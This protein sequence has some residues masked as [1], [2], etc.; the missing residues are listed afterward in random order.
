MKNN[1]NI[2]IGTDP[3]LFIIN[4]RT[5]KIV[6]A[7]PFI[8][9]TK[10]KPF[11][12]NIFT[13]GFAVQTD[14]VLAEFNIPPVQNVQDFIT[15]LE[16]MKEYIRQL[17]KQHNPDLDI[18]CQAS[19]EL[20]PIELQSD[21][22]KLFGCDPDFNVY[23]EDVN[24][25]PKAKLQNLRTTGMHIHIGFEPTISVDKKLLIIRLL[26]LYL[27]MP[28][29]LLDQD[30][31]RRKLYGKAGCF[32]LTPYGL[33]YR[34]LS[35]YFLSNPKLMYWVFTNTHDALNDYFKMEEEGDFSNYWEIM[36]KFNIEKIINTNDTETATTLCK[37]LQIT[38]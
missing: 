8:P 20:D 26:D 18:L 9:G 25:A 36:R 7:I 4:T 35:G 2:T 29:I 5:Q 34:V 12:P 37:L 13:D 21:Q 24:I 10:E 19:A 32:R 17:V 22:A 15:Y 16:V 28:A 27:G 33:E 30:I 11:R 38:Y 31:K 3:E 6:S 1:T 14:N 23:T